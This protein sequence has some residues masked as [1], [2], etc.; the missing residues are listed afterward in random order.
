MPHDQR[1]GTLWRADVSI[2]PALTTRP[3][4]SRPADAIPESSV[5]YQYVLEGRT[6]P[7]WVERM[8]VA[9][10]LPEA[11]EPPRASGGQIAGRQVL[12]R[13]PA[14]QVH[15]QPQMPPDRVGRVPLTGQGRLETRAVRQQRPLKRTAHTPSHDRFPSLVTGLPGRD[16][17]TATQLCRSILSRVAADH[18]PRDRNRHNSALSIIAELCGADRQQPGGGVEIAA[19]QRHRLATPQPVTASSPIRVSKV[20]AFSGLR[21]IRA[22]VISAATSASEYM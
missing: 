1:D 18:E 10:C 3:A 22:A 11:Q 2:R 19:V 13:K 12:F 4:V 7:R 20:A 21:S 15:H 14:A 17:I 6:C 9:L 5:R 8:R 16:S